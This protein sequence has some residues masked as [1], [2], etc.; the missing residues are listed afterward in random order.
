MKGI[1]INVARKL[2]YIP[3]NANRGK[4]NNKK[5]EYNG[6]MYD[7]MLEAN[8]AS[9]LDMQMRATG[10]DRVVKWTP[11]VKYPLVV[12]G[13]KICDYILDFL[14]E[15]ADGRIRYVDVKGFDRKTGKARS[16]DVYKIKKKLMRAI[17][18]IDIEED[19]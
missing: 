11:Q 17:H 18:C 19:Q 2:G 4:Y 14:I 15:Y 7:S 10:K 1:S 13:V 3:T 9:S 6:R 16:T 5:T 12:D 8:Y